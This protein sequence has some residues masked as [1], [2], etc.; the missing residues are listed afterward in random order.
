[1]NWII[2]TPEEIDK[3][4]CAVLEGRRAKHVREILKATDGQ[5]LRVG[6]V[7]GQRGSARVVTCSDHVE[8]EC[9]LDEKGPKP[10]PI[11]LLLALP[12]PLVMK[13]LWPQLSALGLQRIILTNASKVERYY[14]DT[15]WLEEPTY[16]ALMMEGLEQSG[17]TFMP[18]VRIY[19]Q[20]KVLLADDVDKLCG[21]G[22]RVIAD[23][24]G[25][26]TLLDTDVDAA[27]GITVAVGPEGGWT[28]YELDVFKEKGFEKASLGWRTLRTETACVALVAM[29]GAMLSS[30]GEQRS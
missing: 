24:A 2:M 23:P 21:E 8:L 16:Q 11:T 3:N 4:G 26:V 25:D 17:G 13:R 14:F 6:I 28:D 30:N 18:E 12:R 19:K 20:L 15:H 29:L 5:I 9:T 10:L 7:N 1:M 22:S 27:K